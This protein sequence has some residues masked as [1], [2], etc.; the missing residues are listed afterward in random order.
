MYHI[1]L[2]QAVVVSCWLLVVGCWLGKGEQGTG[3]S[4]QEEETDNRCL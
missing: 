1:F 4:Y 2:E 3:N